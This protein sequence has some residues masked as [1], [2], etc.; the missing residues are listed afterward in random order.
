MKPSTRQ[1]LTYML[2]DLLSTMLAVW[3]FNIVR[4]HLTPALLYGY[5]SLWSFMGSSGVVLSMTIFAPGMLIVYALSG[6][7]YYRFAR[8]RTDVFLTTG[9]TAFI[10]TIIY[11]FAALLNDVN[12]MGGRLYNYELL[13]WLFCILFLVVFIPR[14][15]ITTIDVRK[16]NNRVKYRNALIIGTS[17]QASKFEKDIS[18]MPISMGLN[19]VGFIST[20]D[21][22]NRD[23]RLP[24]YEME[25]IEEAIKATG[26]QCLVIVFSRENQKTAMAIINRLF[27]LG[28]PMYLS[29]D[30]YQLLLAHGRFN[31][32]AGEPLIDIS[33]TDRAPS[34]LA[35]KRTFDVIASSLALLLSAPIIAILAPIIKKQSPGP[36]FFKQER[37]GYHHR[38]FK[39]WKLRSMRD[40]AEK[41]G[42]RLSSV[43][44]P[45]I[46]PVGA[47]MRKYRLD[48][49]PNFWNVLK[50]DMSI[51]GPRPEREHFIREIIKSAPYY[52]L[53]HQVRPGITSWG[54]VKYGYATSTSQMIERLKYDMAYLENMSLTVDLEIMFYTIRTVITGRGI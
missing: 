53:L 26:C 54:M 1:A 47:F 8:S 4:Y 45:R 42:P 21:V 12:L 41:Q 51:V 19:I 50:G 15:I 30:R 7:Y 11:F 3:L 31:N 29:P 43:N 17:K 16:I 22:P 39:I 2:A 48:E 35:I 34:I 46:T 23:L 32:V 27:P 37:V 10:G 24:V 9:A 18:S 36:V 44:D 6:F 25:D 5:S 40:D 52:P 33:R 49:L 14:W 13:I 28:M 20:G 38:K